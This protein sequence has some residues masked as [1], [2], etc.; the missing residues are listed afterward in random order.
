MTTNTAAKRLPP[1]VAGILISISLVL[2]ITA[3]NYLRTGTV[4]T[5]VGTLVFMLVLALGYEFVFD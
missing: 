1:L 2:G 5:V 3:S 4:G